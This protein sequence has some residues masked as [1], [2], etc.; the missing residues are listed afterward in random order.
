M[1]PTRVAATLGEAQRR[2]GNINGNNLNAQIAKPE[3]SNQMNISKMINALEGEPSLST[4]E[5]SKRYGQIAA[6]LK[7]TNFTPLNT[8]LRALG[9][10][11]KNTNRSFEPNLNAHR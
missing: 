3:T 11:R 8:R 10:Q 5:F 1:R 7:N 6:A 2:Q 9:S 4:N